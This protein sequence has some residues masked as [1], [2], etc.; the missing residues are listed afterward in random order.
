MWKYKRDRKFETRAFFIQFKPTLDISSRGV[1]R[2]SCLQH[3]LKCR[4][5]KHVLS[6]GKNFSD[7][8]PD[9]PTYGLTVARLA[10]VTALFIWTSPYKPWNLL[11]LWSWYECSFPIAKRL[12][13]NCAVRSQ[14]RRDLEFAALVLIC[15]LWR[16]ASVVRDDT[17]VVV[18]NVQPA[19]SPVWRLVVVV[20]PAWVLLS[21]IMTRSMVYTFNNYN[22]VLYIM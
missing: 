19:G 5:V 16:T 14:V 3:S 17:L 13:H 12:G 22:Y 2:P 7:L 18:Y 6:C 9:Y 4:V 10:G 8:D 1:S 11:R 20:Q 21:R 15:V